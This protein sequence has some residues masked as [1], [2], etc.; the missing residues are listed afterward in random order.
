MED[1]YKNVMTKMK[2]VCNNHPQEI[3][4]I[5]YNDIKNGHGCMYCGLESRMAK[6]KLTDSELLKRLKDND[7]VMIEGQEY[8]NTDQKIICF[9][10]HHPESIF[11]VNMRALRTG[12]GCKICSNKVRKNYEEVKEIFSS[13]GYL[14]LSKEYAGV[15]TNLEYICLKHSEKTRTVTFAML[16]GYHGCFECGREKVSQSK[17][18]ENNPNWKGGKNELN[19]WLRSCV[20]VWVKNK[21]KAFR[22]CFVT[23]VESSNLVLHH[24]FSFHKIRDITFDLLSLDKREKVL[25]YTEEEV[26]LIKET[27]CR[28]HEKCTAIPLLPSIHNLFHSLYGKDVTYCQL[29]EFKNRYL[30]GEI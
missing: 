6:Q 4:Y 22:Q 5:R 23:G 25:D 2:Y 21:K 28:L 13:K 3:Q 29:I 17:L 8:K 12:S 27:F 1:S 18:R 14:L 30:K 10:V 16:Q 15:S 24:S 26:K 20:D 11:E 19:S 7:L 9:C